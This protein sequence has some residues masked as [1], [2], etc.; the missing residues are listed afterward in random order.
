MDCWEL[1]NKMIGESRRVL[2]YGPPGTGKTYAATTYNLN[3]QSVDAT[4]LTED[5]SAAELRGFYLPSKEEFKW[6]YGTG[7]NA[8]LKGG[9]L[10]VNEIDHAGGDVS[11]FLH[12]LLDDPDYAFITLPNEEA[13]VVKPADGFNVVATMNGTPD[14]L[15]P[16]LADRFP[17][18]INI[19]T[20]HPKALEV[21]SEDLRKLAGELAVATDERRTSIRSWIEFDKLR[22]KYT[23]EVAAHAVF[24]KNR[25][26]DLLIAL[27]SETEIE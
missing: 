15:N 10:V 21:L 27:G 8:W 3:K 11:T 4:T 19:N 23:S 17:V 26:Q 24:G 2:L 16:A 22:K 7:I 9:R 1:A 13:E 18:K 25:G 14:M 12:A 20:V 5:S 6:Q